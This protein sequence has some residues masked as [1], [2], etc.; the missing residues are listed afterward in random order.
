MTVTAT[1]STGSPVVSPLV[2]A[3]IALVSGGLGAIVIQSVV[4]SV[5]ASVA[6][7]GGGTV[8]ASSANRILRYS[9]TD[10][11]ARALSLTG[12]LEVL[13][14]YALAMDA[15]AWNG[16]KLDATTMRV[17][18]DVSLP[19]GAS[20]TLSVWE[21]SAAAYGT[22]AIYATAAALDVYSGGST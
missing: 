20:A 13:G 4:A 7:V 17:E 16:T 19:A 12:T 6:F 2:T 9:A 11:T 10:A 18:V 22:G 5:A 15:T 3:N 8:I 21:L 1:N 14:A